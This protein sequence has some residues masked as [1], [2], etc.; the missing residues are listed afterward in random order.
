VRPGEPLEVA[1]RLFAAGHT[2]VVIAGVPGVPYLPTGGHFLDLRTTGPTGVPAGAPFVVV[3]D[4][5]RWPIGRL[6]A[7]VRLLAEDRPVVVIGSNRLMRDLEKLGPGVAF[8]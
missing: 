2:V 1:A 4:N 3:R 8:V 6:A 5:P 7:A